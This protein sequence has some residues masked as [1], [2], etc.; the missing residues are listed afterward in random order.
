MANTPYLDPL[1]MAQLVVTGG[2]ASI[3]S[4]S[5]AS[6][7][8]LLCSCTVLRMKFLWQSAIDPIDDTLYQIILEQLDQTEYELMNAFAIGSI[9]PNISF[10]I[11]PNILVLIGQTVPQIDFPEL[12]LVVPP[13]W[14]VGAD[15][16]LPDMRMTGL[17]GATVLG[18]LGVNIGENNVTLTQAEMP[19][20]NHTQ[21]PHSH[22]TTI[23]GITPTGAGPIVAGA[24]LVVPLPSVTGLTSAGNNPTGGDG[25]HNN[26][27]QSLQVA[28][29]IVAQ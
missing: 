1:A 25:S 8:L 13:S 15:I 3:V 11:D 6:G 27:Q 20:H 4:L 18:D 9:F 19:S 2:Y 29:Y 7:V 22:S 16:Q 23:A 5:Q 10:L 17:F 14:L 28:W 21:N 26:I 24:S 12:A